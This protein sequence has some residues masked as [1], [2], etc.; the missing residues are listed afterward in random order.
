MLA[1]KEIR[2]GYSVY[3]RIRYYVFRNNLTIFSRA[4]PA[5]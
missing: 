2:M 5:I 4:F 1:F 3:S